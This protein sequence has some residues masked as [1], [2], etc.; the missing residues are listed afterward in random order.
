MFIEKSNKRIRIVRDNVRVQ[1]HET[2]VALNHQ[3]GMHYG[4]GI[5]LLNRI[6]SITNGVEIKLKCYWCD[7]LKP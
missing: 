4:Q 2:R 1:S 3:M 5:F 7:I 6:I